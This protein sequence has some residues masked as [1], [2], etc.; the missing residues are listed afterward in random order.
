MLYFAKE[1]NGGIY[2]E[3]WMA[4]NILD[5][6]VYM[7]KN[8]KSTYLNEAQYERIVISVCYAKVLL[9][10]RSSKRKVNQSKLISLNIREIW[11]DSPIGLFM[12]EHMFILNYLVKKNKVSVSLYYSNFSEQCMLVFSNESNNNKQ[13]YQEHC[14]TLTWALCWG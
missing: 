3:C 8:N 14:L 13:E 1:P 10:W 12:F 7:F 6:I 2:Y 11:L 5:Y 9:W 4:S